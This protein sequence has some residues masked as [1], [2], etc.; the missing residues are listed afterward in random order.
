MLHIAKAQHV[1]HQVVVA[2][3]GAAL[4]EHQAVIARFL[5]LAEDMAHFM[6]CQKLRLL[7]VD[8]SARFGHG[9]YQI[10]L[11][12]QKSRKLDDIGHLGRRRSLPGL[13]HIGNDGHVIA[14]LDIGQYLQP[15]IHPRAT[16]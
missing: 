4:A 13:V 5:K 14:R 2:K 16:I 10:G 3:A 6:G 8:G 11:A 15:F 7:D 1:H 12:R 9:H